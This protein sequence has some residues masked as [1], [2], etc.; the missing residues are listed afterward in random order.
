MPLSYQAYL[1]QRWSTRLRDSRNGGEGEG[2]VGYE[3]FAVVVKVM[4]E[5]D[6]AGWNQITREESGRRVII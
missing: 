3:V 2:F 1:A 6:G 4:L 5:R